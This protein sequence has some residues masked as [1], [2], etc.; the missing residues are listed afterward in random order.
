VGRY[1]R[2]IPVSTIPGTGVEAGIIAIGVFEP[3]VMLCV[4]LQYLEATELLVT[5]TYPIEPVN[6][7][8]S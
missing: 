6:F 7:E 8:L 5:L 3:Y 4:I 1:R 2:V